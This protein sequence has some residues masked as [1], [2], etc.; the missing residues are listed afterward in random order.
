MHD[1]KDSRCTDR[2]TEGRS[3]GK[4]APVNGE[5]YE[6]NPES[7]VVPGGAISLEPMLEY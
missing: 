6:T 2:E 1:R 7:T 4:S 5:F 3:A